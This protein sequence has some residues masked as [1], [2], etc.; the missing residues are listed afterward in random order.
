MITNVE[1][2]ITETF[3]YVDLRRVNYDINIEPIE[4]NP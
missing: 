2:W 3:F 4:I 1:P